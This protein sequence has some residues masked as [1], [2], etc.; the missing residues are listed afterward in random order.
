[1]KERKAYRHPRNAKVPVI[2][3]AKRGV[4]TTPI[5]YEVPD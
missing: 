5:E 3:S 1:M 4:C 2:Y